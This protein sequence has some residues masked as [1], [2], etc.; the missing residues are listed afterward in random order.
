M[1][2]PNDDAVWVSR[3]LLGDA[4][5]FEVLVERYGRILF[6]LA[7]RLSGNRED[8]E[9]I[10]QNALLR[11]YE[12]L[13]T[14]DP[15]RPF[16]SWIYRIGV[17]EGLNFRRAQRPHEPLE[18]ARSTAATGD[19]AAQLETGERV[20]DAL[21]SLGREHREVVV[22][23]YF[24]GLSYREIGDA[25]GLPEKTVKSRLFAARQ[26]LEARLSDGRGSKP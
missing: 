20:Q 2:R 3:C 18:L 10:A 9:D 4:S 8:A 22:L 12:R 26:E 1:T 11:A 25:V 5:A 6:A 13:E 15:D 17:N 23:K 7:F 16:F 14:Y 24:T 21:M 19:L